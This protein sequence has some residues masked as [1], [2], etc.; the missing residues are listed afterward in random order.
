[1]VTTIDLNPKREEQYVLFPGALIKTIPQVYHPELRKDP[2]LGVLPR[3][4]SNLYDLMYAKMAVRE[5]DPKKLSGGAAEKKALVKS[6]WVDTWLDS[7]DGNI[8]HPDGKVQLGYGLVA[9]L[10]K[11]GVEHLP[12]GWHYKN[13][14]LVAAPGEVSLTDAGPS[15]DQQSVVFDQWL[16]P[17]KAK[18]HEWWIGAARGDHTFL[19]NYVDAAVATAREFDFTYKTLM[20]VFPGE[21]VKNKIALRPVVLDRFGGG[22]DADDW[23]H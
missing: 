23:R 6:W 16:S 17:A 12:Q 5:L 15:Y 21:A 8:L 13:G 1:M 22:S 20:G 18:N 2:A 11:D 9:K 14:M 19:S 7:G 4:A 3:E 10:L